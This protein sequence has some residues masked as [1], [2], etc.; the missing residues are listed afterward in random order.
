MK[1]KIFSPE[2]R[3]IG[4][5]AKAKTKKFISNNKDALI[6]GGA[7]AVTSLIAYALGY[8]Q[9]SE[10]RNDAF[11][12]DNEWSIETAASIKAGRVVNEYNDR[13]SCNME[14]IVESLDE[15]SDLLR[16]MITLTKEDRDA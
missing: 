14:S 1:K 12:R 11:M 2:V 16:A 5:L 8:E 4:T 3:L 15:S 6:A 13:L 9:G 10:D 7:M